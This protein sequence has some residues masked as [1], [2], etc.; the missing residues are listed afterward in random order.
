MKNKISKLPR[1]VQRA[2]NHHAAFNTDLDEHVSRTVRFKSPTCIAEKEEYRIRHIQNDYKGRLC[3]NVIGTTEQHMGK[4]WIGSFNHQVG[5]VA[6][7]DE[8][9]FT[10]E[11][12]K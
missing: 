11:K 12:T 3:F 9:Y 6:H 1:N 4:G 10:D 7:P 8:V 2:I 5:R